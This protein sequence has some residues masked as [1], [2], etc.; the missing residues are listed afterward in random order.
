MID[1]EQIKGI[2]EDILGNGA[3]FLVS[4][5]VS[6]QNN[7]RVYLDGD[8]GVTIADCIKISRHIESQLDRD[9][10]DF[11]LEVSS[12]GVSEGLVHQRQYRKNVGRRL[13]I[14]TTENERQKGTL[15]EVSDEGIT[16]HPDKK[17]KG[18]KKRKV[19]E[20]DTDAPLFLPF[21]QIEEAKVQVAFK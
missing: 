3:I 1:K 6:R 21:G 2:V 8:D 14:V 13:A 12:V 4:L 10:E 11:D 15:A 5:S 19:P 16:I 20:P 7:I 18:K 17:E 9:N